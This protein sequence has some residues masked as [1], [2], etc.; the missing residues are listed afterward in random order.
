MSLEKRIQGLSRLESEQPT[1]FCLREP[2]QS[3]LF[4]RE[5]F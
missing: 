4:D 2:P 5:R 1:Q 3:E